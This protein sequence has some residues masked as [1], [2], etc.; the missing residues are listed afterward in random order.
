MG[1]IKI[2]R[3]E[4]DGHFHG[5]SNVPKPWV[6][7]IDGVDA[8]FGL[9]RTFIDPLRDYRD[10]S[11]ANSGNM[12]GVVAAFPLRTGDLYEVSRLRGR[13]SKRHTAREFTRVVDGKFEVVEDLDVLAAA[14][15]YDG[16]ATEHRCADG[17]AIGVIAGLGM[18]HP[19]GFILRDGRRIFRLRHDHLHE[20]VE[21]DG[22]QRIILVDGSG[23]AATVTQDAAIRWL[24]GQ[25]DALGRSTNQQEVSP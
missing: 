16:T 11:R 1:A 15:K 9:A 4:V 19:L 12:Y 17:T 18:P 10:A 2:L 7:R 25:R 13:P 14:E 20:I 21:A 22:R 3:I 5:S 24:C 6:A 23:N 8:R